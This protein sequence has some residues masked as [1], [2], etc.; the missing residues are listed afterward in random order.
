[1]TTV[2]SHNLHCQYSGLYIGKLEMHTVAGHLPYLSHWKEMAAR[3]PVFSLSENKLLAFAR[4]EWNRLAKRAADE[5]ATDQEEAILRVC[6][7]AVLHTLDSIKQECPSLP[8][9]HIVQN[10]MSRLF[11]L[12]YWH[13]YLDS[14]RFR[15]PS[16]KINKANANDR[17]EGISD[18]LDLC[19]EIKQDYEEG[20]TE[21]QEQEKA[22]A[23]DR[24]MKALRNSWIVPVGNKQLYRWVRAHLPTKYEAD[25]QGWMSTLFM[26][27]ER[28]ICD[29]DKDDI[30]LL[31]EIILSECPK[32]NGIM[33]AVETRLTAIM[34]IY[35][36]NKEAF[37]V[38]FEDFE[39][40]AP[41]KALRSVSSAPNSM[42]APQQKDFPNKVAFMRANALWYLQQRA[43]ASKTQDS[44]AGDL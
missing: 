12:A 17:F 15:F 21:L 7:L 18:Y 13:H 32:G 28:T 2:I 26:G 9:M 39:D 5:Q 30:K 35:T 42:E 41:L 38:D 44:K 11:A 24:A 16:Y 43:I 6:F 29:F 20:V 1:M 10:N 22:A 14:K 4:G 3:H 23:A 37:S 34:N 33:N 31:H 27:S 36:D 40:D 25:A 19:F 8:P